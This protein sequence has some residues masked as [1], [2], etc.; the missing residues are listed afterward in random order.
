V[1]L[2]NSGVAGLDILIEAGTCG[3][4]NKLLFELFFVWYG[5]SLT[6]LIPAIIERKET[7]LDV[8]K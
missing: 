5:G 4:M 1:P 6:R 7:F 3:S 2:G 8:G